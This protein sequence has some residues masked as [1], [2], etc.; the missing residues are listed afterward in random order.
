MSQQFKLGVYVTRVNDIESIMDA[1]KNDTLVD[2]QLSSY[3]MGEKALILVGD[4]A[5][6]GG[7]EMSSITNQVYD[8]ILFA[9]NAECTVG[10]TTF[11]Y[12]EVYN[13]AEEV[14]KY[15]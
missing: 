5:L 8:M 7:Q 6:G 11:K 15:E 1:I 4:V 13:Y 14:R 2:W 9:N 10:I 3:R 12:D